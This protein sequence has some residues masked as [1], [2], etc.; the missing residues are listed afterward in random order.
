MGK[1]MWLEY[2]LTISCEAPA[3][4]VLR[5]L[6]VEVNEDGGAGALARCNEEVRNEEVA[7]RKK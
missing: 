6:F 3:V 5:A 1:A 4:G 7:L 2:F